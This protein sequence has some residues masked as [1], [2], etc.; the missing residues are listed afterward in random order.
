VEPKKEALLEATYTKPEVAY[1]QPIPPLKHEPTS[2][3]AENGF[4][5][6]EDFIDDEF[7]E[8]G[9]EY[10]ERKWMEEHGNFEP[11][12]N[13]AEPE[14]I[15]EPRTKFNEDD[16]APVQPETLNPACPVCN[17]SLD[18]LTDQV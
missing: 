14:D 11:I 12:L 1:S 7:P 6:M 18:G 16:I 4:E 9:E 8:E 5:D 15:A 17:R 3:E 13:E 2:I 10:L